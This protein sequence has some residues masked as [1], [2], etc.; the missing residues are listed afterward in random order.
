M[1][2]AK[3]R[4]LPL[5][6]HDIAP[7]SAIPKALR[8]SG[9]AMLT[10]NKSRLARNA[11]ADTTRTVAVERVVGSCVVAVK[12]ASRLSAEYSRLYL[13]QVG[14]LP[15]LARILLAGFDGDRQFVLSRCHR[16]RRVVSERAR[17]VRCPVE[18]ERHH[19]VGTRRV[20][21][22]RPA[23]GVGGQPLVASL[24]ITRSPV[25]GSPKATSCATEPASSKSMTPAAW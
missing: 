9:N 3:T 23:T 6:T 11:A 1:N 19:P 4:V 20:D 14:A 25:A 7:R 22:K 10:M 18:I 2:A 8:M 15:G 24:N 12:S 13:D 21:R 17:Q 5:R 16:A